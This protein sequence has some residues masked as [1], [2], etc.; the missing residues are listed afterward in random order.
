MKCYLRTTLS[1]ILFF[2]CLINNL[3]SQEIVSFNDIFKKEKEISLQTKDL[4]IH[5][6]R[7]IY[8][9]SDDK[10]LFLDPSGCQVLFFNQEGK[11]LKKIG[12][13]GQ[14]PGEF[15]A[16]LAVGFD[17]TGNIYVAD[18]RGKKN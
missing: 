8:V 6:L 11:F 1:I 17:S 14:G 10:L 12:R 16:P 2:F 9:N 7:E 13:K 5:S 15:I 4:D 3:N 18:S